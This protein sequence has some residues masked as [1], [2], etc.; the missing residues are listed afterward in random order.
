[1]MAGWP[2][3]LTQGAGYTLWALE[4]K[5]NQRHWPTQVAYLAPGREGGDDLCGNIGD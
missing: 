2:T 5:I 3:T 1:M 4:T